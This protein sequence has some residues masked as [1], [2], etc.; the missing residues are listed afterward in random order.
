V[1]AA[2]AATWQVA[3][4]SVARGRPDVTFDP[5][6][7]LAV[8]VCTLPT[9]FLIARGE[10]QLAGRVFWGPATLPLRTP[11]HALTRAR[12]HRFVSLTVGATAPAI[13]MHAHSIQGTRKVSAS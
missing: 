2:G 12:Q 13:L 6:L 7:L 3:A 1:N 11:E 5:R 8:A 10:V 9:V 4:S